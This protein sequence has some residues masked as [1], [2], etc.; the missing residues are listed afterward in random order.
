MLPS[1]DIKACTQ[2]SPLE[3]AAFSHWTSKR[4]FNQSIHTVNFK[5]H[6]REIRMEEN[7]FSADDTLSFTVYSYRYI[8]TVPLHVKQAQ[9]GGKT[10]PLP[11][12]DP[13]ATPTTL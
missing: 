5:Y 8:K 9:R 2:L 6:K 12:L 11:I 13:G 1:S 3:R 4:G 10:M 7:N